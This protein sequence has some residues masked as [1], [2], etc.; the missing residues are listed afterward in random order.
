[1]VLYLFFVKTI[2]FILEC[3]KKC[4]VFFL[5]MML[6]IEDNFREHCLNLPE[7]RCL[8]KAGES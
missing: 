4:N 8:K 2:L 3:Q 1:M 5:F 7:K 6:K